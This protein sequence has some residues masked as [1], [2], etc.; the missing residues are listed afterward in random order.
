MTEMNVNILTPTL[1]GKGGSERVCLDIIGAL[2]ERGHSI[3]LGT[4]EKT[5]WKNVAI[6]LGKAE[7]PDKE[8]VGSRI[9]G[10]FAYGETLNF[11]LLS[12]KMPKNSDITIISCS[13]PWFYCPPSKRVI[14]YMIP[15]LW[16]KKGWREP[17]LKPYIF[18]QRKYLNKTKAKVLLTNS[19][20]SAETI[21]AAYSWNPRVVYPPVDLKHFYPSKKEDLIVSIG[22]F[23]PFKKF[24]VLIKSFEYLDLGK[25]IIIGTVNEVRKRESI[26]YIKNLTKMIKDLKLQNR[27]EILVDCSL[28]ILRNM[29]S[30]AKLYVHCAW[31]EHF[32]ISIVE[33]MASGCVPIVHRS[34]G[35]YIDI[36]DRDRWGFSFIDAQDLSE[37]IRLLLMSD[38]LMKE[39]SEKAI[40]RSKFFSREI[41][42]NKIADIVESS[43]KT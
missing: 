34:G 7:K 5:D 12:K 29:L 11:H 42:R 25:C 17:Y 30:K 20:F 22:R 35:A 39:Y 4:F 43:F 33:G 3:A 27:V 1:N 41:F 2:K 6:F 19:S 15:P 23:D 40:E 9:F 10:T 18:I 24:E 14:I 37:K 28:T 32:G 31:F 26:N 13:S 8:I 38:K 36:T 16:Y 21:R